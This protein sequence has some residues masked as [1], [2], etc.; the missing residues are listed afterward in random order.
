[1]EILR[2]EWACRWP[3]AGVKVPQ[4]PGCWLGFLRPP[5]KTP[6]TEETYG[7]EIAVYLE[8]RDYLTFNFLFK[9]NTQS[10]AG[11]VGK[12]SI[13]VCGWLSKINKDCLSRGFYGS[14]LCEHPQK[15]VFL[16]PK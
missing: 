11:I 7:L 1:M 5:G 8:W 13:S 6:P 9:Y 4:T 15:S 12:K 16:P 3:P 14:Q 10:K 2:W